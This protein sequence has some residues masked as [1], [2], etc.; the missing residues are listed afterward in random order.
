M[1]IEKLSDDAFFEELDIRILRAQIASCT[2]GTKPPD[3]AIHDERC[4][5]RALAEARE[6]LHV[7]RN[8]H[9]RN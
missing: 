5:Y 6:A 4:R 1:D 3:P 9:K 7:F 8:D 2:C